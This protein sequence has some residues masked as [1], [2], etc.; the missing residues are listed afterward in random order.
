[1]YLSALHVLRGERLHSPVSSSGE[2]GAASGRGGAGLGCRHGAFRLHPMGLPGLRCGRRGLDPATRPPECGQPLASDHGAKGLGGQHLHVLAVAQDPLGQLGADGRPQAEVQLARE[3]RRC[4]LRRM[5]PALGDVARDGLGEPKLDRGR[6]PSEEA[7][8]SGQVP[9]DGEVDGQVEWFAGRAHGPK[10]LH[11]EGP[12]L[13]VA[14]AE[15]GQVDPALL[16]PQMEG[17][18]VPAADLVPAEG[19]VL[20]FQRALLLDRLL[21]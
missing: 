4:H 12:H 20:P 6:P 10:A 21:A 3:E 7:E 8:A 16:V 9:V 18:Q 14:M 1:M 13:A 15:G 17:V 2:R 11:G 19:V 5:P